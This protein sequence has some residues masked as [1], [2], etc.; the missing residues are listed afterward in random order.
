MRGVLILSE[1]KS[2]DDYFLHF[3]YTYSDRKVREY[4][5]QTLEML[6]CPACLL[7]PGIHAV[8]PDK[9]SPDSGCCQATNS[10]D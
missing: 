6:C 4:R 10:S 8:Q 9:E 5:S 7:R 3:T 1:V 2:R